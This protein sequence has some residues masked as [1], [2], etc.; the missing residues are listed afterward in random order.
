MT[1]S[2]YKLQLRDYATRELEEA[3]AWYEE[4]KKITN[5]PQHYKKTYKNY[6][7]ALVD[8]FPFLIVYT[9]VEPVKEILVI[10]IF[11]TSRNP[12]IKYRNKL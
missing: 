2:T 6:Q 1:E 5:N 11:H 3:Y 9:V 7:E 10:A 8:R 12:K 4:L